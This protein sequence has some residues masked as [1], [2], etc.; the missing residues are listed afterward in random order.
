MGDD[1]PGGAPMHPGSSTP[2]S[3]VSVGTPPPAMA[4]SEHSPSSSGSILGVR[5]H[6]SHDRSS[7]FTS[8]LGVGWGL[9]GTVPS[10]PSRE[11][12]DQKTWTLPGLVLLA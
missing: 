10:G 7:L 8:G 9:A 11:R 1:C 2:V 12:R 5:S 3:A 6:W 4:R